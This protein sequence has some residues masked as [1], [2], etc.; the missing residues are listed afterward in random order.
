MDNT[1]QTNW[2][3][4]YLTMLIIVNNNTKSC[5]IAQCLSEDETVESYEWFLDCVLHVT[6]HISPTCLFSDFDPTLMK[7]VM[8]KIFNTHHFLCIFYI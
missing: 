4:M 3:N 6:N 1:C 8:S 7:A 2:F 5:F